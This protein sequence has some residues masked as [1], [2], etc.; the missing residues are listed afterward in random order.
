MSKEIII[1][2]AVY[3][4]VISLISVILTSVDK[5]NAVRHKRRVPERTLMLFGFLGGAFA[6]Y[7]TMKL[8]RHK[9][10]HKKFMIGLPLEFIF[11]IVLIYCL[12]IRF[13][14]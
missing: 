3:A 6:M 13:I 8:I 1:G 14:Y 2:I 7:V 5:A 4:A 11:H 12:Y 10:L 9:T